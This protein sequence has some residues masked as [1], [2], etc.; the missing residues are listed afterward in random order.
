MGRLADKLLGGPRKDVTIIHP[1]DPVIIHP[2]EPI[3]IR[4]DNK[5]GGR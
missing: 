2:P 4:P 5:R 1:L 3:I